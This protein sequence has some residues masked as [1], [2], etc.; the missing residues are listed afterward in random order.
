MVVY[1]LKRL[2]MSDPQAVQR[3][4]PRYLSATKRSRGLLSPLETLTRQPFFDGVFIPSQVTLARARPATWSRM[5]HLTDLKQNHGLVA[6]A[7][8]SSQSPLAPK[9]RA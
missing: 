7:A 8:V 2:Y 6:A 9:A 1:E 5:T 3:T 4:F